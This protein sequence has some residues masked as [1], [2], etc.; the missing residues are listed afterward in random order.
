ME[1]G[2]NSKLKKERRTYIPIMNSNSKW[3]NLKSLLQNKTSFETSVK[4][5]KKQTIEQF[6]TNLCEIYKDKLNIQLLNKKNKNLFISSKNKSQQNF[7]KINVKGDTGEL[8]ADNSI[9]EF[10]FYFRE[11]NELMIK[12]IKC[13]N[14][15]DIKIFAPFLCH[16]FYDNFFM[17]SPEQ[18][19]ILYIIYLLF[20]IEIDNLSAPLVESF[21]N[22]SFLGEFLFEM[23][24]KH[25]IKNYLDLVLNSLIKEMDEINSK[26]YSLDIIGNSKEHYMKF[27]QYGINESF[28]DMKNQKFYVNENF[29][30]NIFDK[31]D[32]INDNM[33]FDIKKSKTNSISFK[34][35]FTQS[36]IQYSNLQLNKTLKFEKM[37]IN[38]FLSNNFF[39]NLTE[40]YLKDLL[41]KENSQFMKQFYLKQ[42]KI[43][44]SFQNP[45]IFTCKDYYQKMVNAKYISKKSI[46][47]FNK[48]FKLVKKFIE[49]LLLNLSNKSII[50]YSIKVICCLI[51]R[52]IKKRFKNI[53]EMQIN[54]LVCHFLFDKLIFPV[55]ENPDSS[56]IEKK[57]MVSLNMRKTLSYI[58]LVLKKLIRGELFYDENSGNYKIFNIFII[59]TYCQLEKIV[60]NIIKDVKI[61]QKL[62]NLLDDFYK[63]DDFSL[64]DLCRI[65]TEINYEYFEENPNDFMQNISICFNVEQLLIFYNIVNNNIDKFKENDPYLEKIF[66]K[67]A[68]YVPFMKKDNPNYFVIINEKYNTDIKEILF[69]KEKMIGL[70]KTKNPNEILSKL[71]FCITY[72]LSKME[73]PEHIWAN[74]NYDTFK[75]FNQ[76]N[77]Y[78]TIY[79]RKKYMPLNWYNQYILDNLKLIDKK[80]S[81]DD[82]TLLY[83]EIKSDTK[84]KLEKLNKLNEFLTISMTTKFFLIENRKK[85]FK[86]EL[87]NMKKI[88][89]NIKALLFIESEEIDICLINGEIYNSLQKISLDK[90]KS[91]IN[92][93][94]LIVSKISCCPHKQ[95]DS[96]NYNTLY[97]KGHMEKYHC[98]KIEDF[99]Y[100]FSR[101]HKEITEEIINFSFDSKSNESNTI[102]K[103]KLSDLDEKIIIANSPKE[104]LDVY[105][106]YV[107]KKIFLHPMFDLTNEENN[108]ADIDIDIRGKILK[109]IWNYILKSLC[110]RIYES[111]PI[112]I[113]DAFSVR[114]LSFSYFVKPSH[115]QIPEEF[116][117]QQILNKVQNHLINMEKRRTP[118]GMNEEFGKVVQL[119]YSLYKFFLNQVKIELGDIL[120][121]IIYSIILSKPKRIIFDV[122]FTKFFLNEKELL[123]NIGYNI[124]QAESA[125]DFIKKIDS[126]QLGISDV[127]FNKIFSKIDFKK[128]K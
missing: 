101:F 55:F 51:Y 17:E 116:S 112:F 18:E 69:H 76:I 78:L 70:N 72:L 64:N 60:K 16:F 80:Y 77:K 49:D 109:I 33:E 124:T 120:P 42:L 2:K 79:E 115:F 103:S 68:M 91:L 29:N 40:N 61:P 96:D 13:L 98:L 123:G 22:D 8:C 50:P 86:Q 63:T 12:L 121:I 97:K 118:G 38:S 44:N 19:E 30:S 127:E 5:L 126:R 31:E 24:H 14:K 28:Y 119:I 52:L 65:P 113:D 85:Y 46:E 56:N 25:E 10:L 37:A 57:M 3:A 27:N 66:N 81:K 105:M 90:S 45:N 23:G 107:S 104:I 48:G 75:T 21:L 39:F 36:C 7:Q 4:L 43:I 93:E 82:Y 71:K 100:K 102:Q 125:I 35:G 15:K 117:D 9:Q 89:L 20:E 108:F 67:L 122:S 26:F 92:N 54:I 58:H 74:E 88:E 59:K 84:D 83:D 32:K 111:N 110:I 128:K 73:I 62:E 34:R 106:N 47:S 41:E 95:L 53:S 94:A 87:E 99:A 6:S 1:N 11:N 114:C